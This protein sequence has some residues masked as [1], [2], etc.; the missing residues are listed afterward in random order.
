YLPVRIDKVDPPLGFGEMQA[1]NL[2][3]WKGDRSDPRYHAVSGCVH[4]MLGRQ[5]PTIG[6]VEPRG[7]VSRRAVLAGGSAAAAAAAAAA[8]GWLLLRPAGAKVNTVA[9]LPF[10]NLSGD[11]SQTYFSDGMAE[12]VRS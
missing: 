8:G 9:V 1:L 12:E 3:G 6:R 10:A 2:S 7:R 4:S 5:S 11:P